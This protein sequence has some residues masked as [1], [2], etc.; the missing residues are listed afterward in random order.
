MLWVAG[1]DGSL[2]FVNRAWLSFRGRTEANELGFGWLD[3]V[4]DDDRAAHLTAHIDAF[5]QSRPFTSE[6][7]LRR[8]DGVFRWIANSGVPWLG[9]N[10]E[11]L[12]QI[13]SCTDITERKGSSTEGGEAERHLKRLVENAQDFVYRVRVFPIRAVEYVGGAVRSITGRTVE[14]F[15][16]DPDLSSK[17]VRPGDTPSAAWSLDDPSHLQTTVTHRWI[18][19]DGS[20]VV[21]EHRQA[22][23]YDSSGRFVAIEGIARDITSLVESQ[24]RLRE[25]EDQMRQLV[26][27]LQSAREEE[28]AK[29]AR[30]LHDELGQTLTALKLEIG[31]VLAALHADRLSGTAVDRL[32]SVIGLSEIGLAMVKRIATELR[33]PTL[34]HLGLSEAIRWE[35]LTFQARSGLRCHVRANKK[36]TALT[37]DQQTALFRIFQEALTNIVRHARASAVTVTLTERAGQ[38]E[39]RIRD[40]GRGITDVQAEDP[41]AIGLIGM[42]E[43]AALIGG[44]FRISSRQSK[45]TVVSVQ[46]PVPQSRES[47]PSPR[48]RR[49][50]HRTR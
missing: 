18:H 19:D 38:F 20:V 48:S 10:G 42:R 39:L 32:Q 23:I 21:A 49:V 17:I 31:R 8:A 24:R 9:P 13:G 28:R 27:R 25:S 22:P 11:Y 34:D 5:R 50:E 14:E 37:P 16:A 30:E 1:I 7:R 40:N 12:G 3:G 26:A 36:S 4:H 35:A 45:G 6:F 43:R 29:V 46:V 41:R 47:G 33:P 15:Y 44:L 2:V